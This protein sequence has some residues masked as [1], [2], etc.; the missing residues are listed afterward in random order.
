[1]VQQR[2]I[3][4]QARL[5]L[6]KR[7]EGLLQE[8]AAAIAGISLRSGQR[9]EYSPEKYLNSPP[10]QRN[11]RTRPDPFSDC[12]ENQIL[13]LLKQSPGLDALMILRHIQQ[14]YPGK[15]P[16]SQL[17]SL[18]RRIRHWKAT[19]GPN[20]E[21]MFHQ[22]KEPGKFIIVDFTV[23]NELDVTISGQ[24]FEH[25]LF[26]LRLPYSGWHWS[27][28]VLG[29]ESYTALAEG[30]ESAL[31]RIGGV[32]EQIRTDSLTAAWKN[33]D[34]KDEMTRLFD[35]LCKH[36]GMEGT[37]NNVGKGHENGWIESAHGHLKHQV[38][39]LLMLRGSTD[40]ESVESYRKWIQK[41]HSDN[42]NRLGNRF[43]DEL[44]MMKALPRGRAVTW[45]PV[46]VTVS[47]Y[48]TISVDKTLYTVESRLKGRK[49]TV[50]LFDDRLELFLSDGTLLDTLER[51]RRGEKSTNKNKRSRSI[52]YRHV[53]HSL[54]KKPGALPGLVYLDDL[55][56][57]PVWCR[58][59][60]ALKSSLPE[61]QASRIY[62]GLLYLAHKEN[63]ENN[64]SEQ[65]EQDLSASSLPDLER[66]R[67]LFQQK[68][69]A[70]PVESQTSEVDA[71]VFDDLL[72]SSSNEES[73]HEQSATKIECPA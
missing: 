68:P 9:I 39:Q 13:P 22:V 44:S 67:N 10:T 70:R 58:A 36:Y 49:L 60:M 46:S 11:Y 1:M 41:V 32:P 35:Q 12:W 43:T 26:H 16:D 4:H 59:W 50:H 52:N 19:S 65:L 25:R 71:D 37:H 23:S 47:T 29:G 42:N 27:S 20:R 15:Y 7:S 38:K 53:I 64:I 62:V 51:V 73:I 40:F 63:C 21:V 3:S 18:Q 17:R 61:R 31:G 72:P 33:G 45:K 55:H 66:Y 24:P 14:I 2:I 28:V 69:P 34:E 30:I 48:S 57:S 8:S 56:P 5:Y 54:V 6:K